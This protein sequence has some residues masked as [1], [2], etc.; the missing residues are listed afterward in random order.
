[1]STG[2]SVDVAVSTG[3]SVDVAVSTGVC[4][5]VHRRVGGRGRVHRRRWTLPCP[6]ACRW[7]LAVS[8]GRVGWTLAVSTG[9]SACR[10]RV[11]RR[12]G[13]RGRVG[14]RIGGR[15]R[16]GRRVAWR[17]GACPPACRCGVAVSTG[18]ARGR[19]GVRGVSWP[20]PYRACP[21]AWAWPCLP[22]RSWPWPSAATTAASPSPPS[23]TCR[24]PPPPAP[25]RRSCSGSSVAPS[26]TPSACSAAP[27]RET[28]CPSVTHGVAPMF[29]SYRMYTNSFGAKPPPVTTIVAPT[30]PSFGSRLMDG[31]SAMTLYDALAVARL[32]SPS[33]ATEYVPESALAGRP[34]EKPCPPMPPAPSATSAPT[35]ATVLVGPFTVNETVSPGANPPPERWPA[36]AAGRT[37]R[38]SAPARSAARS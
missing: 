28:A 2:V 16:V 9:V 21:S 10:R 13:G 36:R 22:A 7:A 30:C 27:T 35:A 18:V 15:G 6:P 14:R 37:R 29:V 33:A 1:M 38:P 19:G 25:C 20:W 24:R 11:H 4:G 32:A 3:V 34:S 26:G 17:V 8:T 12:V 23:P 5:R 31:L